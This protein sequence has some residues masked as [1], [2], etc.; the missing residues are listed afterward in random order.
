MAA[1]SE[2]G[3]QMEDRAPLLDSD[4]EDSQD[5]EVEESLPHHI[6]PRVSRRL[7][8]SH[9]LSTWNS[10]VF[11]FGA[12]LYL[13]SIYPNTLL[14]MSAYAFS[15]GLAAIAFS[16]LVGQYI[17]VGNRLKVVRLSILVQRVVVAASCVVFWLL[18]RGFFSRSTIQNGM[19][20]LLTGLACFEKLASILNFVS[21]EKD[22]VGFVMR[23]FII[24]S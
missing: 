6:S 12:V 14:P 20:V 10:R 22:W 5:D 23:T 4:E 2:D 19:L 7:Y 9:F 1:R 8:I 21:V 15:R 17:D 16:P 3:L 18:Y 11:E 13:A 24:F